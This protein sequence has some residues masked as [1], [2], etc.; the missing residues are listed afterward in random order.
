MN[1]IVNNPLF[2][3]LLSLFAF[4]IGMTIY[5]KTKIPIL[6]PLLIAIAIVIAVLLIFH[7]SF[8]TYNIGGNFINAFLGPA[9][10]ILAVPLYKQLQL[11]KDHFVP[12]MT[13]IIVGSFAS[14]TCVLIMG[15]CL[16]INQE[17]IASLVPKSVT[18]PIG[19]E[20][21]S[22]LGGIPS[23]TVIAIIITGI[24][25]SV[26]APMVCKL[27]RINHEVAMGVSIGTAAH[28]VG[29]TKAL[30]IGE[31]HGAMSSLSIGVAGLITVF[32]APPIYMLASFLLK[33]V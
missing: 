4:E 5:K 23:I 18:T 7:I 31:T 20:V 27:L 17:L 12:I 11:L 2:G 32:L 29:T 9:T 13:G 3:I 8:D 25:G 10:V 30:E 6:N 15:S 16:G 33:F 21:A 14:M 1:S 26:I 22:G 28:A 19:V 24:T